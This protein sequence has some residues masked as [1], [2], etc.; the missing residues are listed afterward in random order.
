MKAVEAVGP[1]LAI[2]DPPQIPRPRWDDP[3]K[4][5][6]DRQKAKREKAKRKAADKARKRNRRAK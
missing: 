5:S 6:R 3:L 4:P 1:M 2:A